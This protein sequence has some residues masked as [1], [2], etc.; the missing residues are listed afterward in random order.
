MSCASHAEQVWKKGISRS[1]V[2]R[3]SLPDLNCATRLKAMKK[4]MS[5]T[6][7]QPN[8]RERNRARSTSGIV[9]APEMRAT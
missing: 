3:I 6:A 2:R 7:I 8:S 5:V 9:I 1:N 4:T